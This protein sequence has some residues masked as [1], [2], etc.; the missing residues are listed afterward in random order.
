L[1]ALADA[2]GVALWHT[3]DGEPWGT[4]AVAGH[5]EHWPL[6]AR[7]FRTWLQRVFYEAHGELAHHQAVADAIDVLA[8]RALFAGP[9]HEVHVRI[10][11]HGDALYLDLADN[12][13]TRKTSRTG[14]SSP[15]ASSQG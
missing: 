15:A 2:H 5:H 1:V 4:I 11:Q 14:R 3:P 7:A 6:A 8:G 13:V 9:T 12:E 10:A